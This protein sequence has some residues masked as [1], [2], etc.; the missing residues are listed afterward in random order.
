MIPLCSLVPFVPVRVQGFWF[1]LL[2]A[3]FCCLPLILCFSLPLLHNSNPPPTL[4]FIV[5]PST[6]PMIPTVPLSFVFPPTVEL[7]LSLQGV[8]QARNR[9][10]E[11]IRVAGFAV[12]GQGMVLICERVTR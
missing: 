2:T 5:S 12:I 11:V 4:I 7:L 1:P 3:P 10:A 9:R 6:T 8:N